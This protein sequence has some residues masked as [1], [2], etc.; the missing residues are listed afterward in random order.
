M[1]KATFIKNWWKE[2]FIRMGGK[3]EGFF[4]VF[5][6]KDSFLL[7]TNHAVERDFSLFF[8][9]KMRSF[10]P[11]I[12]ELR[13][14]AAVWTGKVRRFTELHGT[15]PLCSSGVLPPLCHSTNAPLT[16]H[17]CGTVLIPQWRSQEKYFQVVRRNQ[18]TTPI[19]FS[20]GRRL[21][22]HHIYCLTVQELNKKVETRKSL[23]KF[24]NTNLQ[25]KTEA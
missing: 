8:P 13:K 5:P 4:S 25:Q 19:H 3:K 24:T 17:S 2:D 21:L 9:S 1:K 23:W 12:M 7:S 20:G 15:P 16:Q 10:S 22:A 6:I 18:T 14:I 11:Q